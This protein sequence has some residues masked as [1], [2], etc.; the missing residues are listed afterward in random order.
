RAPVQVLHRDEEDAVLGTAIVVEG[1]RV[2]VRQF[3]G[4]RRLEE[5]PLVEVRVAVVAGAEDLQRNETIERR[6]EGLVDPPHAS[7]PDLFDDLVPV[8]DDPA[9]EWIGFSSNAVELRG[10]LLYG[11]E[12]TPVL[13]RRAPPGTFAAENEAIAIGRFRSNIRSYWHV[14]KSDMRFYICP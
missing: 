4:D 8:V 1:D 13:A 14:G 12:Q 11:H 5:E 7:V 2:R 9:D 6:L 10:R 3:C